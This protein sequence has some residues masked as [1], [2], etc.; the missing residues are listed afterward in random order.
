MIFSF[1]W[2]VLFVPRI[3]CYGMSPEAILN[4]VVLSVKKT[5]Q[6]RHFR[7]SIV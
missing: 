7:K 2:L 1:L 6:D 3:L 4:P 5:D